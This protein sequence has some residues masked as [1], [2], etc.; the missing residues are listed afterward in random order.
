MTMPI[1]PVSEALLDLHLIDS[2][3]DTDEEANTRTMHSITDRLSELGAMSA[4]FND[5]TDELTLEVTPLLVA[6]ATNQ[7][8]LVKQLAELRGISE[9]AVRFEVREFLQF[10]D[11]ND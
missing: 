3:G 1:A 10:R 2:S 4:T 9:E 7:M 11:A 6:I 5:E 8:F